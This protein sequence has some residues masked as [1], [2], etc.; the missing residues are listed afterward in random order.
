VGYFVA[1][2][3]AATGA[4]VILATRAPATAALASIRERVPGAELDAVHL[5]LASLASV[6]TAASEIAALGPIDVLINNAGRT[7]GSRIRE[8]TIDGFETMV[9]T[10][11][12]GPFALTARLFPALS[13]HARVVSLGSLSTRLAKADLDDLMGERGRYS[14]SVAYATSK[15]AVHAFA[16]ELDRRLRAAHSGRM[17]LLAHPGFALDAPGQ[18]RVGITDLGSRATR[19]GERLLTPMAQ[20]K[21]RGA[22]PV[23]RAATDPDATGGEFYGPKRLVRGIPTVQKPVAQSANPE[24]GRRLW[25]LSEELTGVRFDV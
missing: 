4:H 13:E 21:D 19:F 18:S 10:N 14:V 7:S 6:E 15:H 3:L 5:D 12:L 23:V 22:W 16:L 9:G 11:H 1:E 17:S 25:T 24:F 8:T 2:Q 20:G